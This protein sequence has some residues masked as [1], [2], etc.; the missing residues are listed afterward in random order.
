MVSFEEKKVRLNL[1]IEISGLLLFILASSSV[2]D[3]VVLNDINFEK[4]VGQDR[5]AFINFYWPGY[6]TCERLDPQYEKLGENIGMANE[7]VLIGKIWY[8]SDSYPENFPHGR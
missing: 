3:V 6:L 1:S 2:A 4:N 5:Y 8:H 7:S